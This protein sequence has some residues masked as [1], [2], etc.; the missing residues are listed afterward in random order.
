LYTP[1]PLTIT[2]VGAIYDGKI[3]CISSKLL[4]KSDK[5]K[6]NLNPTFVLTVIV[7]IGVIV[8]DVNK[9]ACKEL[10]DTVHVSI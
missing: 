8:T 1:V 4:Q 2:K 7:V 6:S 9:L 3:I 5:T 10:A